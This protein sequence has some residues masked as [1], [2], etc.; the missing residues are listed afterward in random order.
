MGVEIPK[1]KP[2]RSEKYKA[3]IRSLPCTEC[4]WP[5][6]LGYIECHHIRTGGM[7]TKAGDNE[8]V[9]LCGLNARGCHNRADKSKA[10]YEKYAPIA[11][12]LYRQYKNIDEP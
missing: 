5:A 4:Q 6:E 3:W 2:F 7:A 12:R 9:P 11:E 1:E 8:S 10:S